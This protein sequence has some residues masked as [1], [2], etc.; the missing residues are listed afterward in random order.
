M[1]WP[2]RLTVMGK[3]KAERH[4]H[5]PRVGHTY[6]PI[7]NVH[8]FTIE[9]CDVSNIPSRRSSSLA[10]DPQ[11]PPSVSPHF[12]RFLFPGTWW[13]HRSHP[14]LSLSLHEFPTTHLPSPRPSA[15]CFL[16]HRL[17]SRCNLF[18]PKQV[19]LLACVC[20]V[21]GLMGA[22]AQAQLMNGGKCAPACYDDDIRRRWLLRMC[23]TNCNGQIVQLGRANQ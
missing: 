23:V 11:Q 17:F 7:T 18:H 6:T 16:F 12:C 19:Y 21:D 1:D 13:R 14:V 22:I 9:G 2:R 5:M 3:A 8:I 20:S 4:M 10:P 15:F